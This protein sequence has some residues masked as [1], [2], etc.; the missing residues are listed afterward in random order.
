MTG[1]LTV[2][3]TNDYYCIV[4][5]DGNFDIK[6]IPTTGGW[7]R[8]YGFINANNGVLARFGAYGSAQNLVHCYIG[9][10]YKG[11]DT[12]QRWNSAGS[13]ITV[14]LSISQTSSG[15][16]LTLHGTNTDGFI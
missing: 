4:D 11:S 10:D 1:D 16:P 2:G 9:T 6:A 8:G 15:K 3:N 12:W 5:T 13:V 14:P 7:N